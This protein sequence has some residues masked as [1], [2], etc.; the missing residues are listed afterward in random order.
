MDISG[1]EASGPVDPTLSV[2]V[3]SYTGM[4]D[5]AARFRDGTLNDT[6]FVAGELA[7]ITATT[8]NQSVTVDFASWA[9]DKNNN[10][11]V[12]GNVQT[13]NPPTYAEAVYIALDNGDGTSTIII[14]DAARMAT[15][16]PPG[17][18]N[19]NASLKSA[20][21]SW[22]S[23]TAPK[24]IPRRCA[25]ALYD[26]Y[27][28]GE[29]VPLGKCDN[30]LSWAS[31][32]CITGSQPWSAVTGITSGPN[33]YMRLTQPGGLYMRSQT[34]NG[35][36]APLKPVLSETYVHLWTKG[37]DLNRAFNGTPDA[38]GTACNPT[39]EDKTKAFD[40]KNAPSNG[41]KWCVYNVS[42]PTSPSELEYTFAV[43]TY[44]AITAYSVTSA[45]DAPER[46]PRDWTLEG[47]G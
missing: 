40:N 12:L 6:A 27:T 31:G 25:G 20:Y 26:N 44:Y 1:I 32:T 5:A 23:G 9:R 10:A 14:D 42:T 13:A 39:T 11:Y 3:V 43:G 22:Q 8:N 33:T 29:P 16:M 35:A 15:S 41:T 18:T 21:Q 37:Y 4:M 28:F 47:C 19:T 7:F 45:N 36:C 34:V 17:M 46:D 38:S 30:G 2:A 24:P